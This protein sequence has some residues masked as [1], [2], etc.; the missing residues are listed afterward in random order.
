M[1]NKK[2]IVEDY[3]VIV[4]NVSF[5]DLIDFIKIILEK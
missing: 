2:S 3:K 5:I 4:S 1:M